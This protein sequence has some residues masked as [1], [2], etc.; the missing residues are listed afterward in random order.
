VKTILLVDDEYAFV[1]NVAGLLED[2]G[3]RVLS[4]ANG[5][6]GLD[7]ALEERPDLV[8]TDLMMPIANGREL[9]RG[10]RAVPELRS[11]PVIMMSATTRAVGLLDESGAVD[12]AA[13]L[14][15]PVAWE[16]LLGAIV[17]LI[18]PGEGRPPQPWPAAHDVKK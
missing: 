14:G 3:Y 18:G 12:V 2:H 8:L 5:K 6:D 15:K 9:V 17:R 1:E 11:L 4:A 13:F 16:K 10:L 7:R